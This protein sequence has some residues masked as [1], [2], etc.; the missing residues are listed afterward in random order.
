MYVL[1]SSGTFS[2]GEAF[3]YI[4]Q[5]YHKATVVAERTGGGANIGDLVRLNDHFVMNCLSAGVLVL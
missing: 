2:A 4:L 3:A 1:T 5:S